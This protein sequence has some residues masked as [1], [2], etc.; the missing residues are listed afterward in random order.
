LNVDRRSYKATINIEIHAPPT[1]GQIELALWN[2]DSSPDR[3]AGTS[4]GRRDPIQ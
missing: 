4:P 3:A 2:E 1:S